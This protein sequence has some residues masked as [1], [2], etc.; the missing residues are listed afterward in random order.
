MDC[1]SKKEHLCSA[2]HDGKNGFG[3]LHAGF[4]RA[5]LC[6]LFFLLN[7]FVIQPTYGCFESYGSLFHLL[8]SFLLS[9]AGSNNNNNN[10]A[11]MSTPQHTVFCVFVFVM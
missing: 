2:L 11:L 3:E 6:F 4:F 9:N 10:N 1:Q 8:C 7:F 5:S